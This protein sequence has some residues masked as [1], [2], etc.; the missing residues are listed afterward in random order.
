LVLDELLGYVNTI[1]DDTLR[2]MVKEFLVNPPA[3]FNAPSLELEVC[4]AGAYQHHSY[5]GGLLEHTLCVVK[6]SLVLCDIVEDYYGGEVSR[7][8]VLAAAVLHDLMKCFCYETSEDGGYL[9]SSF[10]RQIDHLTLMVGELMRRGFPM[11]VV[12]A[13]AAHHG[14][15]GPTKPRSLEALIVSVADLADSEFNG[16]LLRAAEYLLRRGGSEQNRIGSAGEAIKV[17]KKMMNAPDGDG[18]WGK[19]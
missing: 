8:T 7:D 11:E 9:S 6:L 19:S 17:V 18:V 12:H 13:V 3:K 15:V 16:K 5:T 14:D 2:N 1:E 4:P 10:G